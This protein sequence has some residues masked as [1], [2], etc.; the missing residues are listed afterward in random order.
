MSKVDDILAIATWG[1]SD[2]TERDRKIHAKQ[3]LLAEVL[4]MIGEGE[5]LSVF[6]DVKAITDIAIMEDY[7]HMKGRNHSKTALRKAA[8]ERF[9]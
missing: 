5:N 1:M 9:K 3:Q 8:K 2:Q 6:G 4:D 7:A